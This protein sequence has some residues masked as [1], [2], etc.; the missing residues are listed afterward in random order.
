MYDELVPDITP[1]SHPDH[2]VVGH[3]VMGWSMKHD[4]AARFHCVSHD[5]SGY[6]LVM[7]GDD[8]ERKNV[9]EHAIG[10]TFHL[11]SDVGDGR[12]RSQ[13]GVVK[14]DRNGKDIE[15]RA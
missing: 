12:E 3:D 15:I 9:S 4:K 10:R 2:H 11:I 14:I 8:E 13:W 5:A 1:E 7:R 6:N